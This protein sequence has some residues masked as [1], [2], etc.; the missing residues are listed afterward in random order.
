LGTEL[1]VGDIHKCPENHKAKIV[2]ISEDKKV[3]GVKCPKKHFS[4][5]KKVA[6]TTKTPY[7]HYRSRTKDKK[8]FVK[9]FVFLIKI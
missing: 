9:N 8:V 4:K 2:W 1:K 6:D 7:S 3:I 5:I